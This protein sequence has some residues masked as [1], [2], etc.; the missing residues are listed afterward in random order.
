MFQNGNN[1]S[2]TWEGRGN[3]RLQEQDWIRSQ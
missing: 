3:N 2:Q 1:N